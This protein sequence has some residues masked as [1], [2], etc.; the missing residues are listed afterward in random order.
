[1]A[2]SNGQTAVSTPREFDLSYTGNSWRWDWGSSRKLGW[3]ERMGRKVMDDIFDRGLWEIEMWIAHLEKFVKLESQDNSLPIQ[4]DSNAVD[5]DGANSQA[6][7]WEFPRVFEK[8]VKEVRD[9]LLSEP[10]GEWGLLLLKKL[11][12]RQLSRWIGILISSGKGKDDDCQD[13]SCCY[14]SLKHEWDVV[15]LIGYLAA[16]SRLSSPS[17]LGTMSRS[18]PNM[19]YTN[20]L[21]YSTF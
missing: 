14:H 2:Q 20:S 12:V 21:L 8:W 16:N 13:A 17:F 10:D 9:W 18:I 7:H 19:F 3:S 6:D 11:V 15:K 5:L 4:N 1:M